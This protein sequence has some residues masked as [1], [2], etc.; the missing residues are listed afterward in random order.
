SGFDIRKVV[1]E[2]HR[3]HHG[4]KMQQARGGL[5]LLVVHRSVAGAEV[6][7]LLG[8]HPDSATGSDRLVI[9]MNSRMCLRVN[10]EPLRINWVWK[11]GAGAVDQQIRPSRAPSRKNHYRRKKE[12]KDLSLSHSVSPPKIC[13]KFGCTMDR[14]IHLDAS[15]SSP[16][17]KKIVLP[18]D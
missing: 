2:H 1:G 12:Q 14:L 8:D 13:Q 7:R 15:A 10:V 17:T 9:K 6:D 4:R 3:S 5:Q 16:Q 11:S 18:N